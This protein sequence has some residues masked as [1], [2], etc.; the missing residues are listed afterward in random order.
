MTQAN[1]PNT[2]VARS[3]SAALSRILN[4]VPKGYV[5][6]TAGQCPPEKA[7]KLARKFHE[8]Y[9][10]GC[11]PAQRITRKSKGLA[12]AILVMY[13]PANLPADQPAKNPADLPTIQLGEID[14]GNQKVSWL[15]LVTEGHGPVHEQES[16]RCVTDKPNLVF[17]GYELVRHHVRGKLTWTFRRNKQEMADWYALLAAQINRRQWSDVEKTLILISRQPGFAGVRQQSFELCQFARLR[18]YPGELPKLFFMQKVR[19]GDALLL[20]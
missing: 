10:I 4:L 3:K 15:L 13:W 14:P 5:F 2:P 8:L 17:L 16:L 20:A 19:Q 9:G 18:G 6:Y 1:P 7:E 12:N 11:T